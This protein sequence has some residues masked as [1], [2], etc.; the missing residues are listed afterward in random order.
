MVQ[1]SGR[2]GAVQNQKLRFSDIVVCIAFAAETHPCRAA[3][4]TATTATTA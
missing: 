1:A 2:G 3:A 4:A